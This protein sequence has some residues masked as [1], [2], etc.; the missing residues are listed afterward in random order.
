MLNLIPFLEAPFTTFSSH[1]GRPNRFSG[2]QTRLRQLGAR[3]RCAC[4][5]TSIYT[6]RL[7]HSLATVLIPDFHTLSLFQ[8]STSH[9][10]AAVSK[11]EKPAAARDDSSAYVD[12][13]KGLQDLVERELRRAQSRA[14][15]EMEATSGGATAP[16]LQHEH[17]QAL[18]GQSESEERGCKRQACS[19]IFPFIR[20]PA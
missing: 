20:Q 11:M 17:G 4:K 14:G 16:S 19:G 5:R 13:L 6:A 9:S 7:T 18:A 12:L 15:T 1:K 3:M 8:T 2:R 10:K